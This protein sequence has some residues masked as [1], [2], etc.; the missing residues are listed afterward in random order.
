MGDSKKSAGVLFVRINKDNKYEFLLQHRANYLKNGP[1]K[2]SLIHGTSN[3]NE[4]GIETAY[5]EANEETS[6]GDY[7]SLKLFVKYAK[8]INYGNYSVYLLLINNIS[9]LD[10]WKPVPQNKFM[11]EVNKKIFNN[12]HVWV[13]YKTLNDLVVTGNNLKGIYMWN[14]TREYIKTYWHK[15]KSLLK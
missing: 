14:L 1:G 9:S 5:R 11:K 6:L 12:G 2:L 15:I 7:C 10:D 8:Q 3:K 4:V 13:N